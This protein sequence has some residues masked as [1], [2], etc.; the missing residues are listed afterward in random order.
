[1]G[2]GP[3]SEICIW[4]PFHESYH[5]IFWIVSFL[6]L[7]PSFCLYLHLFSRHIIV[8]DKL[9]CSFKSEMKVNFGLDLLIQSINN[10]FFFIFVQLIIFLFFGFTF[11][12]LFFSFLFFWFSILSIFCPACDLDFFFKKEVYPGGTKSPFF[13]FFCQWGEKGM[14]VFLFDFWNV[15]LYFSPYIIILQ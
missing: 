5:T 6:N 3:T 13:F 4:T 11:I 7:W 14:K 8:S 1:M 15:R 9:S 12:C 10:V 2:Y